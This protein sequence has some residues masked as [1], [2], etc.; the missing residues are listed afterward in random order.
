M[1][2]KPLFLNK[3]L[4]IIFFITLLAVMGV[5][6]ITPAFPVIAQHFHIEYKKIGY[7]ITVFT[8]PGIFLTP[9]LGILADRFGRKTILVPALFLFALAG[10]ACNFAN[11]YNTL[12]LFRFIQG[13][14][15][16]SLG[17]LNVT[18]IGDLFSKEERPAAMGYNAS[19]LSI[20]TAA[21]PAL[22]GSLAMLGWNYP[23]YFPLLAIP[24]GFLVLFALHNEEPKQD[25]SLWVYLSN[26]LQS[27]M[28]REVI[29]LF[30]LNVLTFIILYGS[31]LTYFPF[32]MGHRF[33]S[34]S[35]IIGIIMS[36]SSV[37]TAITSA[38][39]GWLSRNFRP[40][41]QLKAAYIFYFI[42]LIL[43]P[44]VHNPWLMILPAAF[45]GAAQGIN[46][47]NIQTLLV[48]LAP[49]KYRAAFM[50][51]NGMVLRIGQTIGPLIIGI[52]FSLGGIRYAFWGGAVI[53]GIMFIIVIFTLGK[54]E[55]RSMN[56]G[57]GR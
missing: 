11:N 23:F 13:I 35:M 20:G 28:R 4:Q 33:Q 3:N 40:S 12:L 9:V 26:T 14:G 41:V 42:S 2:G 34:T 27:V 39:M 18:L 1:S 50:S 8:L 55:A 44:F 15:G 25:Q 47:P 7:L 37:T 24:A 56:N 49:M 53:S 36:S 29:A 54:T 19:V 45:F 52:F 43:I 57:N 31:Y 32:I 10:F 48:S 16:A 30:V 22:G 5:A 46:I 6:S 38:Q 21:Y 51:L 17:S